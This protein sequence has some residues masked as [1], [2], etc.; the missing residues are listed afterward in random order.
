MRAERREVAEALFRETSPHEWGKT[1]AI[2]VRRAQ[3]QT[4][5]RN[6]AEYPF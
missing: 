1:L 6:F 3:E 5:W 2:L 4:G